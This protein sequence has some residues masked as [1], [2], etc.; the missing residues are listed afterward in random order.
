MLYL[1]VACGAFVIV[2]AIIGGIQLLTAI[3][4]L[5]TSPPVLVLA[6]AAIGLILWLRSRGTL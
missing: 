1:L 6:L 4:N 5:L 2:L 3:L